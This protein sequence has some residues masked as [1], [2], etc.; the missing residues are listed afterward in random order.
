MSDTI[1]KAHNLRDLADIGLEGYAPYLMNRI[2]GRYNA[3][4]REEMVAL[5][6]STAKMRAL[7][8]L[9]VKDGLQI[10]ELGIYAVV[11]QSTLSRALEGLQ[12]DGLIDRKVDPDDQR[13]NRIYL[14][15][16]GRAA[17][18][19]L[20]PHMMA[21]HDRMFAGIG[22][23]ERQAFLVTLRKMLANIRVHEI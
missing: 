19:R 20:W 16:T 4:L 8:I 15:S 10:G 21:S 17:Y 18:D 23:E 1:D 13:S 7:A 3:N 6:L 12:A 9:S 22:E 14:T 11:E 5:G 2:M